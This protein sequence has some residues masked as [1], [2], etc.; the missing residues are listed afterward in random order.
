MLQLGSLFD[1]GLIKAKTSSIYIQ[2]QYARQFYTSERP[3]DIDPLHVGRVD[4][5]NQVQAAWASKT[6]WESIKLVTGIRYTVRT[7]DSPAGNIG[8]DD[9]SDEKDYTGTRYWIALSRPLW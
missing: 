2:Y 5:Q 6:I 7:A 8:E 1:Q 9:P 4:G 3:L